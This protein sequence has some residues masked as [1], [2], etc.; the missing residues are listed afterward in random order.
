MYDLLILV[1]LILTAFRGRRQGFIWQL[2]MIGSL[3][4]AFMLAQ[5]LADFI[6]PHFNV[7]LNPGLK[8]WG[9]MLALYLVL[10]FIG[11]GIARS[12]RDWMEKKRFADYDRHLGGLLGLL[13]GVLYSLVF[14]FFLVTLIPQSHPYV[15]GSISGELLSHSLTNLRPVVP[16]EFKEILD[17]AL[18]ALDQD[19]D[20]LEQPPSLIPDIPLENIDDM[21]SDESL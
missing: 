16:D 9:S 10:S 6:A 13:K 1:L 11:Y 2:A 19:P 7:D 21:L 8:K 17:K 18:D 4:G 14:T 15:P 12:L 3:V 20:A 5:P